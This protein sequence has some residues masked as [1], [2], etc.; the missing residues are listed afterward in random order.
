M[1]KFTLSFL[2]FGLIA[3]SACK[4]D[5]VDTSAN[6]VDDV[7]SVQTFEEIIAEGVTIAFF[8]ASWCDKCAEQ[9]PAFESASEKTEVDFATFIE[10]EYEDNKEITDDYNVPG[11]PT[12]IIFKDGTEKDRLAG[13][14][15]S[16]QQ[17]IDALLKQ[18]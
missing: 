2:I 7:N 17:I 4:K 9:R 14:G 16:E 13:K 8:H 18:K 10:I 12:M 3:F 6:E 11:F 5:L 15:H 1:N